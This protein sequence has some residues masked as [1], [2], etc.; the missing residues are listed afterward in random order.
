LDLIFQRRGKQSDTSIKDEIV[1][2]Y[3]QKS[4]W[5]FTEAEG[6]RS[7]LIRAGISLSKL[8]VPVIA[9]GQTTW[10]PAEKATWLPASTRQFMKAASDWPWPLLDEDRMMPLLRS[11]ASNYSAEHET[12]MADV[13][14][15][16]GISIGPLLE[17]QA[18]EHAVIIADFKNLLDKS[19]AEIRH[20]LAVAII[21][22]WA[23][24]MH[25][26]LEAYEGL[27]ELLN[28]TPWIPADLP[29]DVVRGNLSVP[30]HSLTIDDHS[31]LRPI[32][33]WLM[34]GSDLS[35]L[36]HGL[37]VADEN[38]TPLW[39]RDLDIVK[40]GT[41]GRDKRTIEALYGLKK[42]YPRPSLQGNIGRKLEETYRRLVRALNDE[43]ERTDI[44]VLIHDHNPH[45]VL[46][47]IRWMEDGEGCWFDDGKYQWALRAFQE[48]TRVW[49]V[50][51][52]KVR[53]AE[54]LG[55]K[56]FEPSVKILPDDKKDHMD[57]EKS[58][59]CSER[60]SK[61]V[62]YLF[63]AASLV[64]S[65]S[66]EFKEDEALAKWQTLSSSDLP[67]AIY[68]QDVWW[69]VDFDGLSGTIGKGS[70]GDIIYD[71]E[72]NRIFF[73]SPTPPLI[74]FAKPLSLALCENEAFVPA[75]AQVLTAWPA[76]QDG[77]TDGDEDYIER[78][79]RDIGLGDCEI[80]RWKEL[81]AASTLSQ[82]Q[83]FLWQDTILKCLG[84]FG[85]LKKERPQPGSFVVD[86]NTWSDLHAEL[87]Q[88]AVLDS[89]K[90]AL[91]QVDDKVV[92]A[93]I[94]DIQIATSNQVFWNEHKNTI[95]SE[96]L[97]LYVAGVGRDI[98][99]CSVEEWGK[100]RDEGLSILNRELMEPERY[101]LGKLPFEKQD[102]KDLL[103]ARL[104]I[105]SEL[106]ATQVPEKVQRFLSGQ[107]LLEDKPVDTAI[108]PLAVTSARITQAMMPKTQAEYAEKQKR[109]TQAGNRAELCVLELAL[110]HASRWHEEYPD[111]FW[112]KLQAMV[113]E[114]LSPFASDG[115]DAVLK[116]SN[117][118][119]ILDGK[120]M[121]R[122][123]EILQVSKWWGNAGFDVLFPEPESKVFHLVEVKSVWNA[124]SPS[125]FFSINEINKAMDYLR[126]KLIWRI[127]CVDDSGRYRIVDGQAL[128]LNRNSTGEPEDLSSL[129]KKIETKGYLP[130]SFRISLGSVAQ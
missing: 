21:S 94:P 39:A 67:V 106:L 73:D 34:P 3:P 12:I 74:W 23:L 71:K 16:M 55:L 75:F 56:K 24:S 31:S 111:E 113:R 54:W 44:P 90:N 8:C 102:I 98:T 32:D 53:L 48:K 120:L 126:A 2:R 125:F 40:L 25:P 49:S 78:V 112:Q 58:R 51:K 91:E 122:L 6:S 72:K 100:R 50:R 9:N 88:K 118:A 97:A 66:A 108:Q 4:A 115:L 13:C 105:S 42:R 47:E 59:L 37:K 14:T 109:N 29:F 79:K 80:A 83:V 77:S 128:A 81:V 45:G 1:S 96:L 89:L 33:L 107:I 28:Q 123:T 68:L 36:L 85:N 10:M 69:K 61:A 87:T 110:E 64:R 62:P 99:Y 7:N 101:K 121:D 119:E 60:I 130:E 57:L 92:S 93:L 82:D 27:K 127:W 41:K 114:M 17:L 20:D 15:V 104:Q 95:A 103:S 26:L 65:G 18:S 84:K 129:L 63:A 35:D 86:R 19:N 43:L 38:A 30:S 22:T 11:I 124:D 116:D 52:E 76:R 70:Q 117:I 46:N 5:R